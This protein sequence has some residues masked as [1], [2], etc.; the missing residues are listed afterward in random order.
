[1]PSFIVPPSKAGA[2]TNAP[3]LAQFASVLQDEVIHSCLHPA[4]AVRHAG[5]LQRHFH[6]RYGAEDH[7]LVQIAEM[8]DTENPS[9]QPVEPAAERDVELVEAYLTCLVGVVAFGQLY[10]GN[11]IGLGA[12]V[13]S[14]DLRS[15]V[16]APRAHRTPCRLGQAIVPREDLVETLLLEH[17]QRF[18][19][20]VEEVDRRSAVPDGLRRAAKQSPPIPI[21]ARQLCFGGGGDRAGADPG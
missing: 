8:A 16:L 18:L 10:R 1:M 21:D 6:R 15:V 4:A 3:L 20:P 12:G 5:Q 19:Q 17:A 9:A 7:R 11:R 2:Y 13:D 14:V